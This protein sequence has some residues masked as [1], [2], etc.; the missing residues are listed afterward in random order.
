MSSNYELFSNATLYRKSELDVIN[1]CLMAIGEVPYP[2]GTLPDLI[3]IG[4]DGD[5]ARRIIATTMLEVQSRGWFFNTDYS[6]VLIPDSGVGLGSGVDGGFITVPPNMLRIDT[7]NQA[8]M[9]NRYIIK[10]NMIYD[11]L[12]Q[13]YV[14]NRSIVVDVVWLVDYELLPIEAYLYIAMR[15]ARKFQQ[16]VIGSIDLNSLTMMDEQDAYNNLLR[17]QMQVQDYNIQNPVVSNRLHNGNI[18][19]GLYLNKGRRQ[20]I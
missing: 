16:R 11:L 2:E 6:M 8:D 7:G 17:L 5:I 12:E 13:D 3:Q 4:T 1:E 20:N 9:R 18:K 19:M 15:S 14:Q 10:D